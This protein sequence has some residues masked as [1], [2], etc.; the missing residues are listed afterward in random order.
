MPL[1]SD[2]ESRFKDKADVTAL[3][4]AFCLFLSAIEYMLPKPMPFMRLGIAN[5]PILLAVDLLP[6]P[7]FLTLALVKVIG[8]SMISGSLFSFVALFSLS[9]TMTAA[10]VMWGARKAGGAKIS[11]IGTSILGAMASNAVQ[12][13]LARAVAFGEAAWLIAP[14]FLL[15]GL[16]T[17]TALGV[18][19]EHFARHSGWLARAA[20]RVP[21]AKELWDEQA[22]PARRPKL[23]PE[24]S[25]RKITSGKKRALRRQHFETHF[26]P[27][28]TALAG[29]ALAII[30][31]FENNLAV[32][33][34][35]FI[36]FMGAVILAGKRFSFV[37]MLS[38]SA[39]I[40]AAN[41][42]V[43]SG[44]VL[45]SLGPLVITQ[46]ALTEGLTK[47]LTFEGLMLISKASIMQGLKLP[48]RIGGIIGESFL[49]YDRI[50]EYKGRIRAASLS[51]DAD[52]MM[53]AVWESEALGG[54]ETASAR[55]PE[56]GIVKGSKA[57]NAM[58]V[59]VVAA[60]GLAS[61]LL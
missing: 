61:A 53:T 31:L 47:A 12:V 6:F 2:P 10:V 22:N 21:A 38:V 51:S 48:G 1:H 46:Y 37:M 25:P 44:K 5:L 24:P 56:S 58:L 35:M 39:G 55:G 42:L 52:A 34:G 57:A 28:T 32:K 30:F 29:M 3:L 26:N 8:M 16:I 49:Y 9:G 41:L 60:F 20:G 11:Q 45:W 4:G 15:M 33:T 17:G 27:L 23:P 54:N 19:A 13:V 18:F 59:L 40:V 36:L 14:V 7:W 43:P 50:I